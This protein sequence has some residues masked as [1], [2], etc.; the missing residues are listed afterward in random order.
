MPLS[1]PS[2]TLLSEIKEPLEKPELSPDCKRVL[3]EGNPT[4][5]PLTLWHRLPTPKSA[6][7]LS[8]AFTSHSAGGKQNDPAKDEPGRKGQELF[9]F[10]PPGINIRRDF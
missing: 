9:F 4:A 2:P 1:P 3:Q 8:S 7:D 6:S 5:S 10:F